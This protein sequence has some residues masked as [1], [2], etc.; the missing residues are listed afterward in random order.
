M[1]KLSDRP[2][3][4]THNSMLYPYLPG[5]VGWRIFKMLQSRVPDVTRRDYLRVF[6]RYTID[7]S[8]YNVHRVLHR[9]VVVILGSAPRSLGL[10]NQLV[11]PQV[12]N[13]V[14]WR[15]IPLPG[16]PWYDDPRNK[17]VAAMVFESLYLS[18]LEMEKTD[19]R[20]QCQ[21]CL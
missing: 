9:R 15:L 10:S 1:V 6:D 19:V 16:D 17:I 20:Y 8:S 18:W 13:G 4:L 5:S 21:E 3:L 2:V 7:E 11:H 12:V 14:T